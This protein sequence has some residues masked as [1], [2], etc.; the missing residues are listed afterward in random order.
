MREQDPQEGIDQ[1]EHGVRD[2]QR[3]IPGR[4]R[5][6]PRDLRDGNVVQAGDL[7]FDPRTS[8]A[9]LSPTAITVSTLT[10][11]SVAMT[12]RVV[13]AKPHSWNSRA[14]AAIT[15]RLVP[16]RCA[17]RVPGI[18]PPRPW[19]SCSVD[20]F[21]GVQPEMIAHPD[22]GA[23]SPRL[24]S[25]DGSQVMNTVPCGVAGVARGVQ[26]GRGS[27]R[28]AAPGQASGAE[29]V[30]PRTTSWGR[31]TTKVREGRRDSSPPL[32]AA[33]TAA[34]AR[35]GTAWRMVVSGGFV[36]ADQNTSS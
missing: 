28:S 33:R 6:V 2:V 32:S 1:S 18:G 26:P 20:T 30:E 5:L 15:R 29:P 31:T 11:H 3:T 34:R 27:P 13:A 4:L 35:A 10:S 22:G 16:A 8:R 17:C 7:P 21:T 24:P 36:R 14:A 23:G 9:F 12:R 25:K 19:C